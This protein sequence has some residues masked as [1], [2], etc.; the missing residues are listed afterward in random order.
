VPVFA[1]LVLPLFLIESTLVDENSTPL[2]QGRHEFWIIF[3]LPNNSFISQKALVH[4]VQLDELKFTRELKDH[5]RFL[6]EYVS[7][8]PTPL[9]R[10][11]HLEDNPDFG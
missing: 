10:V 4:A 8:H 1:P 5:G 2:S 7:T 11:S 3:S 9:S 6:L